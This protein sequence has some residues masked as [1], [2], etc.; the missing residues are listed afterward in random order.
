MNELVRVA[1]AKDQSTASSPERS[2]WQV[3]I[4]RAR[5]ALPAGAGVLCTDSHVMTCAHVIAPNGGAPAGPV[6]VTFQ[7]TGH[8]DPIP[9]TVIDN[10][11]HP[12][13]FDG[14]GDIAV[15]VLEQ[16]LP[17]GA[18]PAPLRDAGRVWEHRFRAY[19]YPQGHER[20]GV[21]SHGMMVGHS[22]LEWIQREADSSW[23]YQLQKGFRGA[24]SG[25]TTSRRSSALSSPPTRWWRRAPAMASRLRS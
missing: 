7:F 25:T 2:P 5:Q 23:G 17:L 24:P 10:G 20:N 9:A 14:S 12:E 1:L 16:A 19:G 22:G 8:H 21:W 11:W 15:V 4:R 13:G 3:Q 6:F 18:E